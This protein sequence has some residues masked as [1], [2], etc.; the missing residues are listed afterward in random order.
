MASRARYARSISA[1]G[2]IVFM[3]RVYQA[4][5]AAF[6]R[7]SS[8]DVEDLAAISDGNRTI[9]CSRGIVQVPFMAC[10]PWH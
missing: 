9:L 3:P 1:V 8:A 10:V 7:F 5:K 2:G 6:H 4:F